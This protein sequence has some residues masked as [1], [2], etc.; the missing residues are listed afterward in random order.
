MSTSLQSRAQTSDVADRQRAELL[1]V[2]GVPNH[3][4]RLSAKVLRLGQGREC[5]EAGHRGVLW[6]PL[7]R[8]YDHVIAI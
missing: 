7:S 4:L 5:R 1:P 6:D 8:V 2:E 3:V